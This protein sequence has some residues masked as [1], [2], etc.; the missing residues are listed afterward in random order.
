MQFYLIRIAMLLVDY[1]TSLVRHQIKYV[2]NKTSVVW[3]GTNNYVLG[4][5]CMLS[6]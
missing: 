3:Q 2:N 4:Y 1:I 6:K 5:T